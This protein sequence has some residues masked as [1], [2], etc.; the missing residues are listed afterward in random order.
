MARPLSFALETEANELRRRIALGDTAPVDIKRALQQLGVLSVFMPMQDTFSGMCLKYQ[1]K[2]FMLINSGV[3]LGR[4]H[5]TIAHELYHL[6]V[7]KEFSS[8]ICDQNPSDP[9]EKQ[10][11]DFATLFLMP[12]S[13]I[14]EEFKKF[15]I[16]YKADVNIAHILYLHQYFGVSFQSMIYRLNNLNLIS[17]P[18]KEAFLEYSPTVVAKEYGYSTSLYFPSQERLVLGDYSAKAQSLFT[19]ELISEGHLIDLLSE[20]K[21]DE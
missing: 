5:F 4:Q 1:E 8:R 2:R 7:Q 3:A 11:N 9:I 17:D 13:G 14:I 21:L 6:F 12:R 10:A 15:E 16:I 20:I 19:K 18:Q